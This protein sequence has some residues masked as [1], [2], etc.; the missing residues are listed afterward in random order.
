MEDYISV[1]SKCNVGIW[2]AEYELNC[3]PGYEVTILC[4]RVD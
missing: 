1:I 2:M 3:M 4:V